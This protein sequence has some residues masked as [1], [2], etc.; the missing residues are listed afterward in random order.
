MNKLSNVCVVI[1]AFSAVA[2]ISQAQSVAVAINAMDNH[3]S[4]SLHNWRFDRLRVV[5]EKKIRERCKG[6]SLRAA[7]CRL[8]EVDGAP[9]DEK[10]LARYE[11]S[12]PQPVEGNLPNLDPGQFVSLGSLTMIERD[13]A[14]QLFAFDGA[15]DSS[16]EYEKM[17]R[18]KGVM[19]VHRDDGYIHTLRLRNE[20]P[21]KPA[22]GV[23]INRMTID[24]DFVRVG[25]DV[26][27]SD[28]S[29]LV[30][31]KLGGLKS[32][33]QNEQFEFRNFTPPQ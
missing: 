18:Q 21:F 10:A 6:V 1:G 12:T 17:G 23:K 2:T 20:T 5:G 8:L 31:G 9:P 25:E 29:M 24:I 15:A 26:F 16:D 14:F 33:D 27:A 30:E 22:L 32:F 11:K 4:V 13:G 19:R 3:K 7:E 28:V